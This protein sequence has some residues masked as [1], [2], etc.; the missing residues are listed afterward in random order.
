[1]KKLVAHEEKED[2][3]MSSPLKEKLSSSGSAS[4]K[5]SSEASASSNESSST[6][7]VTSLNNDVNIIGVQEDNSQQNNK[8]LFN[9]NLN[10]KLY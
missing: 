4:S 2:T 1:M 7:A 6:S 10:N 9:K 3:Q 5:L 8:F